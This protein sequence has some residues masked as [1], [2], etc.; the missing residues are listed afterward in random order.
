MLL[1]ISYRYLLHMDL[2][3]NDFKRLIIAVMLVVRKEK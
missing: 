3:D 1:D 2:S